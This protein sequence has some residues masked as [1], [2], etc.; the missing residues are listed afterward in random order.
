MP[1]VLGATGV[2]VPDV[3]VNGMDLSALPT[4]VHEDGK[5]EI[6]HSISETVD[7]FSQDR[8]VYSEYIISNMSYHTVPYGYTIPGTY[9]QFMQPSAQPRHRYCYLF[10]VRTTH[11]VRRSKQSFSFS[12]ITQHTIDDHPHHI[13]EH[14]RNDHT[15]MNVIE[16]QSLIDTKLIR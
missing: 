2:G 15:Q 12:P 3:N 13:I 1:P 11:H 4:V 7:V 8:M 16:F 14:T 6:D 9:L 10:Y 5:E